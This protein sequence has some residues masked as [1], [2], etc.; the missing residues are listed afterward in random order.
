MNPVRAERRIPPA[1]AAG[2]LV[3]RTPPAVRFVRAEGVR[4][5]DEAGRS[6]LDAEA[7]NGAVAF[8]Y[9]RDVLAAAHR[10]ALELPALPSF[11]ESELRVRVLTRLESLFSS[12]TG[13][14]GRVAVEL[15]GTQGIEMAMRIVAA[16]R[17]AGPVLTFQGSYH[18][19]S[20]FTAHL[21][22][23]ARYR[24]VQPWPGPQVVRLPYPDC[25]SCP[26]RPAVGCNPACASAVERLGHEDQLGVPGPS[27]PDGV[28]ALILEPLLNVGGAVLPDSAHLRRVVDHVRGLG[29]LIVVDEIFTGMHRLGP[30]WG[31]MLHD[32]QPDVVV[33][34]KALTNGVTPL[35]CVWAREPL[36][37]PERFAVGSHSSTFAGNPH[38]LATVEAVLDRWEAWPNVPARVE[39]QGRFLAGELRRW[40]GASRLVEQVDAVGL[41]VRVRLTGPFALDLRR[42]A[43]EPPDGEGLLL[44]STGM[45]PDTVILHPPLVTTRPDL[46]RM[47]ELLGRALLALEDER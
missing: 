4:L 43:A 33:A 30:R 14:A 27:A 36:A 41:V 46:R 25:R 6:Y 19:R 15:G 9:D 20:P 22:A 34:S 39:A 13:T 3:Y 45:A 12:V 5:Y 10:T 7:A 11:C 16:S 8:G 2:D 26:H 21:S 44:A 28:A 40:C 35:S 47:A 18:G 24:S 29:G 1:L 37:S 23:S 38:A 42:L 17:G 32:I 31:F